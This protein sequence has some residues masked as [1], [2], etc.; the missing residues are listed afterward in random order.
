[1]N[2][3][4]SKATRYSANQAMFVVVTVLVAVV[5]FMLGGNRPAAW[6]ASAA[7]LYISLA[8]Y[9][10]VLAAAGIDTRKRLPD[11]KLLSTLFV[12]FLGYVVAQTLPVAT[13][14]PPSLVR[15]PVPVATPTISLTPADTFFAFLRWIT[16]AALFFITMQI[17]ARRPR[18]AAF[19]LTLYFVTVFHALYAAVLFFEFGDTILLFIPKWAYQGYMTGG[20]VNRNS[21]ATFLAIGCSIG[22]AL[23]CEHVFSQSADRSTARRPQGM[24]KLILIIAGLFI[25][26]SCLIGTG[27]RMGF[28]AGICGMLS[29]I[30]LSVAKARF[31]WKKRAIAGSGLLVLGSIALLL[32]L[33]GA[34]LFERLL[35]ANEDAHVRLRFYEQVLGMVA[36]RPFTGYGGSSFEF[37]YPLFHGM[38]VNSD[39]VWE[40]THNSYFALWTDYGIIFGSLPI[41]LLVILAHRLI[42]KYAQSARVDAPVAASIGT[43]IVAS[44]HSLV[45]FSLE[46][47]GVALIFVAVVGAGIAFPNNADPKG[48]SDNGA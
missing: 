22:T 7:M 24:P 29:I 42:S 9:F 20:F 13:W 34:Q 31:R 2:L 16:Y 1:M 8:I 23:I 47:Q 4:S 12:L 30:A 41:A 5:P 26:V 38:Q 27:S 40:K 43:L 15:L 11:E 28:F 14:L 21:F 19:I 35:E 46:I 10:A 3:M 39:T 17:G 18:A 6:A 45:D 48:E 25:L 37:A 33:Y 44:L 36:Y 32:E